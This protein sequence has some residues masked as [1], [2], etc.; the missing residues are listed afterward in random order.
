MG[1]DGFDAPDHPL[2]RT[3]I[4]M[5]YRQG[6]PVVTIM[7]DVPDAPRL[8]YA[9][10][11]HY[12]AGRSAGFF[13]CHMAPARQHSGKVVVLCH[14]I[15]FQAHAEPV[16]GLANDLDQEL[17]HLELAEVVRGGDSRRNS[18]TSSVRYKA[19]VYPDRVAKRLWLA[20][21]TFAFSGLKYPYDHRFCPG[22]TFAQACHR[23]RH[24]PCSFGEKSCR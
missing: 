13:L 14:H 16:R 15:G 2:I 20:C 11:D 7:S 8:A 17:P 19:K 4:E 10:T 18:A 24:G 22:P 5:L 6:R 1:R 12:K 9:G 23:H 21:R 3:Q